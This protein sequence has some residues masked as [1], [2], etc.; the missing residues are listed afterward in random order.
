MSKINQ[1]VILA[2]GRGTRMREL[3]ADLPKPMIIVRGKPVLQHIAEGLR[4]ARHR[5]FLIVVGYR[6]DAVQN[7]FGD[8]SRYKVEIQ[9]ATQVKQD[10]TGRVVD[11]AKGF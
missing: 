2:A 8:G 1:A 4:G 9:Y 6:A 7:F 11:L 5:K 10:G 3:T